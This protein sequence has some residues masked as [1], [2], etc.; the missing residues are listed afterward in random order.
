MNQI[1]SSI[2]LLLLQRSV[3]DSRGRCLQ[4][5][6]TSLSSVDDPESMFHCNSSKLSSQ[7]YSYPWS[8]LISLLSDFRVPALFITLLFIILAQAMELEKRASVP[9]SEVNFLDFRFVHFIPCLFSHRQRGNFTGATIPNFLDLFF[10][11]SV[12]YFAV[13]SWTGTRTEPTTVTLAVAFPSD[14]LFERSKSNTAWDNQ[15]F[16]DR[17]L[18]GACSSYK[19]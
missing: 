12:W 16:K 6:A 5:I 15:S 8:I 1:I 9:E 2:I 11:Y 18:D 10:P 3:S 7:P 19:S 4:C 17:C 14:Q 13:H